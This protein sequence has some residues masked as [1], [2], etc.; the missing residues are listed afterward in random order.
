[1]ATE[2]TMAVDD[3]LILAQAFL[4]E[5]KQLRNIPTGRASAIIG[6]T[7]LG[8]LLEDAFTPT[9]LLL[10]EKS[11]GLVLLHR[12]VEPIL[13]II[14]TDLTPHVEQM[15]G[16]Q[17]ISTEMNLQIQTGSILVLFILGGEPPSLSGKLIK[18]VEA[19]CHAL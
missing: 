1:M 17:V 14:C 18:S 3:L 7:H 2:T 11:A 19:D 15:T 8:V 10:A 9:E 4:I 16:R 6:L 13:D 12:Y 5:W